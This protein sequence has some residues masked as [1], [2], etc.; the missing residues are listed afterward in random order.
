MGFFF[1][2]LTLVEITKSVYDLSSDAACFWAP[3]SGRGSVTHHTELPGQKAA[4]QHPLATPLS[5]AH[6]AKV[7][8]VRGHA[9]AAR[10]PSLNLASVSP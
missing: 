2:F 6:M 4:P 9:R 8:A 10:Y 1:F 7:G 5:W 3:H